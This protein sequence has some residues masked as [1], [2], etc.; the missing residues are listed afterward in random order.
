MIKIKCPACTVEFEAE[1][2]EEYVVCEYCGTRIDLNTPQAAAEEPAP[3][4]A[5][6]AAEEPAPEEA[7]A[8]AEEPAPEEAPAAA[9]EPAPEVVP[10]VP[11]EPKKKKKGG[12]IAL[13]LALVLLLGGGAAAYFLLLKPAN[14]YKAA[15][16]LM[17][18]KDYLGA[19]DA[20]EALGDYKDS[21]AK[22]DECQLQKGTE[23]LNKGKISR[24]AKTLKN[25]RNHKAADDVIYAAFSTALKEESSDNAAAILEEMSDLITDEARYEAAASSAIAELAYLEEHDRALSLYHAMEKLDE[26]SILKEGANTALTEVLNAGLYERT[27]TILDTY[28]SYIPELPELVKSKAKELIAAADFEGA[29]YLINSL[30]FYDQNLDEEKYTLAQGL[31]DAGKYTEAEELFSSISGYRDS[32]DKALEAK[33]QIFMQYAVRKDLSPEEF[34]RSYQ[35][36][37]EL[38]G[39]ADS[40][41]YRMPVCEVWYD[42]A[43]H[44]KSADYAQAMVNTVTLSDEEKDELLDHIFRKTPTLAL[45]DENGKLWYETLEKLGAIG[46]I[47]DGLYDDSEEPAV[48]CFRHYVSYMTEYELTD[49]PT[50][51]ELRALWPLRSDL[52]DFCSTG[53]PLMAFLTGNWECE[54]D[55]VLQ[56]TRAADGHY[57][58]R[59]GYDYEKASG[60]LS[61]GDGGLRIVDENGKVL[62]RLCDITITDFNA[63]ELHNIKD[64][65]TY[66]LTR[67]GE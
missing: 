53:Y 22:V 29:L 42:S 58:L 23:E 56:M 21:A 59:Y 1:E 35:L 13:I 25:V 24:A 62:S 63:L 7:P 26:D 52:A 16:A 50:V 19:I 28:T 64:G 11:S 61:A 2:G 5:P 32:A 10:A 66:T 46:I 55:L 41:N 47:M 45:Y 38:D 18:E 14:D 67:Q 34:V 6:A 57:S 51:E 40:G 17:E 30:E 3:K 60:Y 49:L 31:L 37:E 15:L 39:Y 43:V 48:R 4:E 33:Y 9:E 27:A 54:D 44:Y 12:L 65:K 8:A 20:F 36:L